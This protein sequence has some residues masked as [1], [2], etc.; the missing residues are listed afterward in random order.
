MPSFRTLAILLGSGGL[1]CSL[2][3]QTSGV[4]CLVDSDCAARGFDAGGAAIVCIQNACVG[5]GVGGPCSTT[6]E[7]VTRAAGQPAICRQD[8]KE[9]VNLLS[10]DCASVYGDYQSDD[11]IVLGSILSLK[12]ANA[13][14]GQ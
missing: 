9:C 13:S 5:P 4:Q 14:S 3:V 2:L 11:A 7:C 6:A 8:T 12:G 1:A 10:Q